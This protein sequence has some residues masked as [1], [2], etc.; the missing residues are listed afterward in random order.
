MQFAFFHK[1]VCVFML[2]E[3]DLKLIPIDIVNFML[4]NHIGP[5]GRR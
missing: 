5:K 1:L 4:V 3:E 2:L